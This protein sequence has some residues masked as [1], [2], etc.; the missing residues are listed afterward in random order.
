M[1]NPHPPRLPPRVERALTGANWSWQLGRRHWQ[2]RIDNHL[3]AIWPRS[4]IS[5]VTRNTLSVIASI[6]RARRHS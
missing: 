6:R 2:I 3:V 4:P 1:T 5:N